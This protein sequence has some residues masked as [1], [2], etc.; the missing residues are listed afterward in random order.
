MSGLGVGGGVGVWVRYEGRILPYGDYY[1]ASGGGP[2]LPP[3][4]LAGA[5]LC[6][7]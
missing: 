5:A 1:S 4:S 2:L 6:L 3:F 7:G